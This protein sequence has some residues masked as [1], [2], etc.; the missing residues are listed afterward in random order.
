MSAADEFPQ[1]GGIT[2]PP[3]DAFAITPDDDAE[4]AE[5]TRGIYVGTSG[6]LHVLMHSGA[7]VTF[8]NM[9]AGCIHP[10]RVKKVFE[11]STV[12]DII[13]VN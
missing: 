4:L 5:V 2:S 9:V 13:G 6:D 11:D 1:Q 10:M 3:S 8:Q 12:T 7:E